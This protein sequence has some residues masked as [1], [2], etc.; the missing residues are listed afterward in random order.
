MQQPLVTVICLCYNHE[1]FIQEALQSVI[2]QVYETIEIIIVDDASTDNSL[3]IIIDFVSR[4]P[5]IKFLPLK[6]N[7]GNCKAF[8]Q[9]LSL[10]TGEFIIDFATDDVM[11]PKRIKLQVDFFSTLEANYGVVFTDA[12]YINKDG[13]EIK[14]HYQYLF[15]KGL[16]SSIPQGDVYQ[17]VLSRYFISS[18]TMMVKKEVY[19]TLQGYDEQLT[20]EDFDFW[21]RSSRI[22]K[23]GFL[24]EI[25]TKVRISE[26][27]MSQGWYK[28]GDTQLHSTYLV[29][30]KAQA[31]NRS[32]E[33][34]EALA[35]RLRYEIR[36]AVFSENYNEAELFY[37]LL[38]ELGFKNFWSDVL[39][40]LNSLKLPLSAIRKLYNSVRYGK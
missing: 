32:K 34:N 10:A 36:Q 17:Q 14:K 2:D 12:L 9:G 6:K 3:Q 15:E 27:S 18:P 22:F 26:R 8:N 35:T 1:K 37:D 13:N 7:V 19:N 39:L 31:L 29:C 38:L 23:Y 25:T 24:N 33:D 5:F 4:Y 28:V 16:L 21:V 40:L 30:K 20:Y 11:L